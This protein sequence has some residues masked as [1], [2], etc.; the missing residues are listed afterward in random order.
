[1]LFCFPENNWSLNPFGDYRDVTHFRMGRRARAEELAV[2]ALRAGRSV[3]RVEPAGKWLRGSLDTGVS[4]V[5]S[6]MGAP[7]HGATLEMFSLRGD[8]VVERAWVVSK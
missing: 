8:R 3:V 5:W 7:A 6:P 1:M 2:E 4:P